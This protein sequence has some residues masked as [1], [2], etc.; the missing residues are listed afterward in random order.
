MS[1]GERLKKIRQSVG[2][3][4]G[5][6]ISQGDFAAMLGYKSYT[7]I[8]G[9]ETERN[10]PTIQLIN[11]II[12]LGYS[13]DWL[14]TGSGKMKRDDVFDEKINKMLMKECMNATDKAIQDM[15][16]EAAVTE[17]MAIAIQLYNERVEGRLN[18]NG[19]GSD[20]VVDM[21]VDFATS[22]K[23]VSNQ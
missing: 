4:I 1:V 15:G 3:S 22:E 7:N 23:D 14:M 5:K 19:E 2:Q 11:A 6:K 12:D 8:Q 13:S 21:L 18:P 10:E 9:F 20:N 17:R 16:R